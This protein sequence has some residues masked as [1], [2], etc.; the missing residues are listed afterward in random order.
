MTRNLLKYLGLCLIL[1]QASAALAI[2]RRARLGALEWTLDLERNDL[3]DG[4]YRGAATGPEGVRDLG[5]PDV[6]LLRGRVRGQADSSVRLSIVDGSAAGLVRLNGAWYSA[7]PAAAD[8]AE[9]RLEPLAA[10]PDALGICATEGLAAPGIEPLPGATEAGLVARTFPEL[11]IATEADFEFVQR[12]GGA[13]SAN[14]RILALLNLVEALYEDDLG[15]TLR[16]T[17]QHAW[18]TP[19]N[20]L[21]ST[22]AEALLYQ[23]QG[24]GNSSLGVA[25]DTVHLFSGKDLA[26]S[27]IGIAYVA[28][29]CQLNYAYGLSQDLSNLPFD[30]IVTAH[31]IGHNLSALHDPL[32][33]CPA[34]VYVMNAGLQ[35]CIEHF[36]SSSQAQIGA[37]ID[38]N[39]ACLAPAV[40]SSS[41]DLVAAPGPYSAG[42][43]LRLEVLTGGSGGAA[44]VYLFVV[45]PGGDFAS[46]I[47]FNQFGPPGQV[48]PLA[49][50]LPITSGSGVVLDI[51]LPSGVDPGTYTFYALLAAPGTPPGL[52][53]QG[54][55]L[56]DLH[57]ISIEIR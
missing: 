12:Y 33:V 10:V 31:E 39:G 1:T 42:S 5:Y 37:W 17:A 8:R 21:S 35:G 24:Y 7:R 18:E 20:P 48:A 57:E 14:A 28:A 56:I 36:S 30:A 15:L 2:E 16:V 26:G 49:T 22:S 50:N 27:V 44:D 4:D 6:V 52:L 25:R 47:G 55:A 13:A 41:I 32:L 3:I 23:L 9:L 54:S 38:A 51:V 19:S 45:G 34:P 11:E 53:L 43:A 40:A 29:T 46:L